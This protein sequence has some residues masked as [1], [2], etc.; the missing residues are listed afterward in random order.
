MCKT[1]CGQHTQIHM[2]DPVW[3]LSLE[4]QQLQKR[5]RDES[6]MSEEDLDCASVTAIY[7]EREMRRET[8]ERSDGRIER[9]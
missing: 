3:P 7:N 4:L 2:Y 8:D 1:G 9:V 6:N 5:Q